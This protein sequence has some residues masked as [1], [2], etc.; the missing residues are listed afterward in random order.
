VLLDFLATWFREARNEERAA[1]KPAAAVSA[2]IAAR[3]NGAQ[4]SA[5]RVRLRAG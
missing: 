5:A 3:T 4:A 1:P 2:P